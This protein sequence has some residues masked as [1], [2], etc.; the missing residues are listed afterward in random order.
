MNYRAEIVM[1][2]ERVV[3]EQRGQQV[4]KVSGSDCEIPRLQ[5]QITHMESNLASCVVRWERGASQCVR[6]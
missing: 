4:F 2:S 6:A 1:E 5:I 3:T